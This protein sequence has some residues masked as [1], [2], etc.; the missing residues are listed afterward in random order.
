[1]K[2]PKKVEIRNHLFFKMFLSYAFVLTIAATLIGVIYMKSYSSST[3]QNY[4]DELEQEANNIAFKLGQYIIDD[5]Y[6]KA[7]DYLAIQMERKN[8]DLWLIS[9][10]SAKEPMSSVIVNLTNY[11]EQLE[12]EYIKLIEAVFQGDTQ[13]K[14]FEDQMH[15]QLMNIVGVP[16]KG[17][18]QENVGAVIYSA[19][20]KA[21]ADLIQSSIRIIIQCIAA[22]LLISFIVAYV[23]VKSITTP[24][25]KMRNT[26]KSLAE[27]DY[28]YRTN[29]VRSDEIGQLASAVDILANRLLENENERKNMEQMRLDF[30]ANVSHELRT[31]ITVIRAYTETLYDKVITDEAKVNQY[32]QR[33]LL[34]CKS[35]ERLVGDLL[36]LSKMQNPDFMIDKEPVNII[37]IFGDIIR[38]AS[39]IS[40]EKQIQIREQ[41]DTDCCLVLG[42]YDRLRQMFMIIIDNAIKFSNEGSVIDIIIEMREQV[43]ITIR[44]YGVG[45]SSEELPYI[46]DKFYKSKLRQNAKGSGLGLAIAR[47]IALKHDGKIEVNSEVGVGTEF[48]FRFHYVTEQDLEELDNNIV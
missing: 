41:C 8:R 18:N 7:L 23:L 36:V 20:A 26:A 42:D 38:S 30:F 19:S 13:E 32:Y 4:Y 9:N 25:F 21:Q 22:A 44:D 17:N 47:Q 2:L 16:I 33:M 37:Q 10:E 3:M 14:T 35:M 31:P 43:I 39:A 48:K 15:Q 6:E 45:I 24:I 46:F 40:K 1:M 5:D 11:R 27:G 12:D 34:E 29:V 28:T